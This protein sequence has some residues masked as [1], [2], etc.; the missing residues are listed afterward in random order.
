MPDQ[1]TVQE[2]EATRDRMKARLKGANGEYAEMLE[3]SIADFE[4]MIQRIRAVRYSG[5]RLSETME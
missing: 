5:P 4:R 3:Q 1:L 2:L